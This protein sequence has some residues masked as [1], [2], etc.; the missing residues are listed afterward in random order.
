MLLISLIIGLS[1]I[2]TSVAYDSLTIVS[3]KTTKD[4]LFVV[5]NQN[6]TTNATMQFSEIVVDTSDIT[7]NDT[8][9]EVVSPNN[10]A[11]ALDTLKQAPTWWNTSFSKSKRYIINPNMIDETLSNFPV[12][13]KIDSTT[14]ALCDDGNS[15]RFVSPDNQTEYPYEIDTWN[16]SGT[17]FVW[18]KIPTVSNTTNTRFLMYY[19]NSNAVD[20]ETPTE[21]WDD[22]YHMVQ[23][24]NDNT[25]SDIVDS[26]EYGNDGTKKGSNEPIEISSIIAN[27]QDFNGTDYIE[28]GDNVAN[29]ELTTFSF[30]AWIK[31]ITTADSK[32]VY[33]NGDLSGSR[34]GWGVVVRQN[35]DVS[36][37]NKI[38]LETSADGAPTVVYGN[39]VNYNE[40]QHIAVTYNSSDQTTKIYQNGALVTDDTGTCDVPTFTGDN[41][42]RIGAIQ[43]SSDNAKVALFNGSIDEIRISN[44]VKSDS[45]INA[46]YSNINDYDNFTIE[47]ENHDYAD[48]TPRPLAF[49]AE[50][51]AGNV[52]FNISGFMPDSRYDVVRGGSTIASRLTD[53][54]GVLRFTNDAWS[55]QHFYINSNNI[56]DVS[57]VPS[58]WEAGNIELGEDAQHN[59]T[60][61]QNGTASLDISIGYNTTNYTF[62]SYDTWKTN[63]NNRV[64]AN[65]TADVWLAESNIA[66]GYPPSTNLKVDFESGN[67]VFG[68]RLWAPRTTLGYAQLENFDIVLTVQE[69]T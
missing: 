56:I 10:I 22:N 19:N 1:L 53:G 41:F 17:S 64:C 14:G 18:V 26:T 46:T 29:L 44:V 58:V 20:G 9:F 61:Y 16:N 13:V 21:V 15:I 40:W 24:M 68:N 35:D 65:Y 51:S 55:E 67:F 39:E 2:S 59:F 11:I 45:Y 47:T 31:P 8:T 28:C 63:G 49:Y 62:V 57:V 50:T 23:H 42:V 54:S 6:Y 69:H 48:S 27:G 30:S 34:T 12:L 32:V 36:Y 52:S 5:S 4:V 25:T 33:Y 66:P 3:T 60:F 37:P 43:Q 7:F 38:Y